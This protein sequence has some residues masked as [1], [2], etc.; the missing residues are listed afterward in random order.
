MV[1][2]SHGR[3][4]NLRSL[5]EKYWPSS[6]GTTLRR[7]ID[8]AH[9]LALSARPLR[10]ELEYVEQLRLPCILHW[11]LLHY[12]VLVG[13]SRGKYIVFDPARGRIAVSVSEFSRLFTGIAV[14]FEPM[15]PPPREDALQRVT[16][17]AFLRRSRRVYT[18]L[19]A[20]VPLA[21]LLEILQ[22][23]GPFY[24]QWT[25]DWAIGQG[26][27]KAQH[28]LPIVFLAVLAGQ[29][30]AGFLRSTALLGLGAKVHLTWL[31]DVFAHILRL[32]VSF[33][34]RRYASDLMGRFEGI[35]HIQRLMTGGF[36]EMFLDGVMSLGLLGMMFVFSA[37]LAAVTTAAIGCAVMVRVLLIER[38]R[39]ALRAYETFH[40]KQQGYFLETAQ[41]ISSIKLFCAEG[42][43]LARWGNLIAGSQNRYVSAE[44]IQMIFRFTNLLIFG[45]ERIF[46]VWC[47]AGLVTR[48]AMSLGMLFSY[49]T[50]RELLAGR[51]MN[52]LEK[53]VE[54][55]TVEIHLDRLSD[56]ALAE[57]EPEGAGQILS[58]GNG[59]PRI[60]L[61][62]VWFRY[63][64]DENWILKGVT[65]Q[66][67]ESAATA[68]TGPSGCGKT[69]LVRILQGLLKP[70]KGS[71]T[72]GGTPLEDVLQSYRRMTASVNQ[73]EDLLMGTIAENIAFFDAPIDLERVQT[74]A[75]QARIDGD[76]QAMPMRYNTLITD[77][78]AGFSGGQVQRLLLA[79]ALYREPQ[80]LFLD[81]ATS[82]LDT[83]T[84]KSVLDLISQLRMTR[85]VV[86][87]RPET[88]AACDHVLTLE[89]GVLLGA[90][91][92]MSA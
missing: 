32:P 46:V 18:G 44:R 1:L 74:A 43:R 29:A 55:K 84:E 82:H 90:S 66:L 85:I 92:A 86:A 34:E 28:I 35:F 39:E 67:T 59:P 30:G 11:G 6:R 41:S 36:L 40:G 88:I 63:S 38:L 51:A 89:D 56:I 57:P 73:G 7:L 53:C 19:A 60:E 45:L 26:D 12:V 33:F 69:T 78:G 5:R 4:V 49:V 80:I 17:R 83:R 13:I 91:H 10:V 9:D 75:I 71:V 25:V 52:L 42:L 48:G 20:L 3:Q 47:A 23:I 22:L 54:A 87:H 81:E 70:A 8:I 65:A 50:Y 77:A 16:W 76:I 2:G 58:A 24:L 21:I 37:R 62:D 79:R 14:E 31:T 27:A 61:N 72:V 15:G 64:E 68:I